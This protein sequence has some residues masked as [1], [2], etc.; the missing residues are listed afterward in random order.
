MPASVRKDDK[1]KKIYLDLMGEPVGGCTDSFGKKKKY[2][3]KKEDKRETYS[4]NNM[5]NVGYSNNQ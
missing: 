1:A 4:T 2:V 5:E 3:K